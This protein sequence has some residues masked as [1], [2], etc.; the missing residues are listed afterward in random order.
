MNTVLG[1][2]NLVSYSECLR[3]NA[4]KNW[5]KKKVSNKRPEKTTCETQAQVYGSNKVD[6]KETGREAMDWIHL[7]QDTDN[8]RL[9]NMVTKILVPKEARNYLT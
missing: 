5:D 9:V 4:E 6:L 3:K 1:Y 8:S 7:T 2:R